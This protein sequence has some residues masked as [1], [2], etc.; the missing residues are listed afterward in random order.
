MHRPLSSLT[1]DQ[2]AQD[3]QVELRKG[4]RNSAREFQ[5]FGDPSIAS[6][7]TPLPKSH[8]FASFDKVEQ[9][10]PM[11]DETSEQPVHYPDCYRPGIQDRRSYEPDMEHI[12]RRTQ[13]AK[14]DFAG[15]EKKLSRE[16]GRKGDFY[17]PGNFYRSDKQA[18]VRHEGPPEQLRSSSGM[19]LQSYEDAG[20][21]DDEI[22]DAGVDDGVADPDTYRGTGGNEGSHRHHEREKPRRARKKGHMKDRTPEEHANRLVRLKER[23]KRRQEL[24]EIGQSIRQRR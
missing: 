18:A 24:E 17:R 11:D 23:Q 20:A 12:N 22:M 8:D 19:L 16:P 1:P 15:A 4:E 9:D 5:S 13:G 6:S 21:D 10:Q 7:T 2:A 14:I 3:T